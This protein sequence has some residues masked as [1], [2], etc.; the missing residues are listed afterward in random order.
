MTHHDRRKENAWAQT[1]VRELWHLSLRKDGT[2]RKL[3]IRDLSR[4]EGRRSCSR[5][6]AFPQIDN[7]TA[8]ALIPLAR[9][10]NIPAMR[11][12]LDERTSLRENLPETEGYGETEP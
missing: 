7:E 3:D 10:W 11:Q 5:S 2:G 4:P 8:L 9:S 12:A 1:G 6:I